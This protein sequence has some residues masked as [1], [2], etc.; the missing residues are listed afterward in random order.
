MLDFRGGG[1]LYNPP[2]R[3]PGFQKKTQLPFSHI[4]TPL[5]LKTSLFKALPRGE[6]S[7]EGQLSFQILVATKCILGIKNIM[8]L[9]MTS[10]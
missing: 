5:H 6:S 7:M 9:M 4:F 10:Y 1:S 8:M 3:I 2:F